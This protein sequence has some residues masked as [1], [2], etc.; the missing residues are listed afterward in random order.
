MV[1]RSSKNL[2]PMIRLAIT[3]TACHA[4]RSTLPEDAP[5]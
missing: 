4:I 5:R 2:L 1:S 3:A